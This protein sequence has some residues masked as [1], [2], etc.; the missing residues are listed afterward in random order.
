MYSVNLR[1]SILGLRNKVK[2]AFAP[3]FPEFSEVQGNVSEVRSMK[4][5]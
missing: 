3:V 5:K 4:G 1:G 2:G